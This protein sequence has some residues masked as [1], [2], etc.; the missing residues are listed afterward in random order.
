MKFFLPL[1]FQIIPIFVIYKVVSTKIQK[2]DAVFFE[3]V[4]FKGEL[5]FNKSIRKA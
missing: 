4:Q 1:I 5:I 2:N 3:K